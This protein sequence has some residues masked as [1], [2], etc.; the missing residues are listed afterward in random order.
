[1]TS[2]TYDSAIMSERDAGELVP[3]K[4]QKVLNNPLSDITNGDHSELFALLLCVC[5][6]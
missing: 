1:M 2:T 4:R 6:S 5:K 3:K